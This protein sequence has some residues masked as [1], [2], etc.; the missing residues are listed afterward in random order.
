MVECGEILKAA[1][2]R[3]HILSA[4]I[5]FDE[6]MAHAYM[7]SL[8]EAV[9]KGIWNGL[10]PKWFEVLNGEEAAL[11]TDDVELLEIHA[12]ESCKLDS[13]FVMRFSYG[14]TPNDFTRTRRFSRRPS[15][16]DAHC[17]ILFWLKADRK[18]L[19]KVFIMQCAISSNPVAS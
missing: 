18:Q 6:Q 19:L 13:Y 4:G 7:R 17:L 3:E 8:K 1:S 5:N 14:T 11:S 10:C 2:Q 15:H 16:H 9:M 12:E